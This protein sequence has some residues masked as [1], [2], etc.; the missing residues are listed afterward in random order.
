MSLPRK[1]CSDESGNPVSR[2]EF[3]KA[4]AFASAGVT[5]LLAAGSA[6]ASSR[7][8]ADSVIQIL[9]SGGPGQLDTFDPKPL[10]SSSIRGPFRPIQTNITGM[11]VSELLPMLA[12][13][14]DKFALV[15][16]LHQ[17]IAPVHEVGSR[18]LDP[19]S[20]A[21]ALD[22]PSVRLAPRRTSGGTGAASVREG[23]SQFERHCRQAAEL[24][25]SG[26]CLVT[27]EMF[28]SL[29]DCVSW[30]CHANES[31]LPTTL[32]DYRRL[33]CP[34]FDGGLSALLE[35]LAQTGLLP[36]T[37]V[38]CAGEFGRSPHLNPRG[39]RD[40]WTGV[41]SALFAGGGV[42][43]GQV[44]GSSDRHG[45]EPRDLPLRA[46]RIL[47]TILHALGRSGAKPPAWADELPILELL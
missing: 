43:G 25:K 24:V 29:Y 23:V 39:G 14:A 1:L 31:D 18:L 21:L 6:P 4:G 30:D 38:V 47:P 27:I 19:S 32:D 35:E 3:M 22:K 10:A 36:R 28:P 8:S 40:H 37:L 46:S 26:P 42:R 16:S 44:I 15:R 45:A 13:H 7:P 20:M 41:W 2:R 34:M 12:G 17:D 33:V 5:T 11:H 9:L